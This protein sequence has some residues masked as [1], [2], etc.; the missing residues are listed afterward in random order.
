MHSVP[1]LNSTLDR[2]SSGKFDGIG[3]G[4]IYLANLFFYSF[5]NTLAWLF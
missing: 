4:A 3:R 2:K 1:V 5:A